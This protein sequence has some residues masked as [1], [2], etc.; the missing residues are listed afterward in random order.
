MITERLLFVTS[1]RLYMYIIIL[2]HIPT[3]LFCL[4]KKISSPISCIYVIVFYPSPIMIHYLP[5]VTHLLSSTHH[6]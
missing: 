1:F 5:I 3:L 2:H 6:S 4:Q